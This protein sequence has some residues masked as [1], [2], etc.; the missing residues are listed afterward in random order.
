[1]HLLTTKFD[2]PEMTI[3]GWQ[4][5]KV[6]ILTLQLVAFDV[7]ILFTD[8]VFIQCIWSIFFDF[9]YFLF[10]LKD[11]FKNYILFYFIY[12]VLRLVIAVHC[13]LPTRCIKFVVSQAPPTPPPPPPPHPVTGKRMQLKSH[14]IVSFTLIIHSFMLESMFTSSVIK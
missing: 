4:D 7:W 10:F 5:V 2:C 11:F 12:F 9:F 13:R 6:Q 3:R 14:Y 8:F 1:M